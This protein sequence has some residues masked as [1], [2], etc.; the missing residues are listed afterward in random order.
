M[1]TFAHSDPTLA[2]YLWNFLEN[3]D[4]QLGYMIL[5]NMLE[6]RDFRN[7]ASRVIFEIGSDDVDSGTSSSSWLAESSGC[8]CGILCEVRVTP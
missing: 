7:N 5:E 4:K 2:N 1:T 8:G 6:S 3:V